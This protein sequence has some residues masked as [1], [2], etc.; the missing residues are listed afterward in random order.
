VD[1]TVGAVTNSLV[2][3]L[4][5]VKGSFGAAGKS[6]LLYAEVVETPDLPVVEAPVVVAEVLWVATGD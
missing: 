2:A 4:D 1:P 5:A 6:L 3:P